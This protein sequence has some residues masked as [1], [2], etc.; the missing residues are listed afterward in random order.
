MM[1]VSYVQKYGVNGRH[2]PP[3]TFVKSAIGSLAAE[4]T[5]GSCHSPA[6][7][8]VQPGQR[9]KLVWVPVRL[10]CKRPMEVTGVAPAA[11]VAIIKYVPVCRNIRRHPS[12]EIAMKA[13]WVNAAKIR[14]V[15]WD[16]LDL[17]PSG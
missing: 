1:G 14:R 8:T 4:A 6:A 11:A 12:L 15:S 13:A 3:D 9:R 17:S 7:A 5:G 2:Q 16:V 10:C